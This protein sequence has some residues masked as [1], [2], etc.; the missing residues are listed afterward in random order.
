MNTNG[1]KKRKAVAV[2]FGG[3]SVEHEISIITG[4]QLIKAIDTVKYRPIPVY[5]SPQGKWYSGDALYDKNFY[6]RMPASL[7]N[8]DEVTILPEPNIKG[9][10]IRRAR[11]TA[12]A[13]Y[14]M[15]SR[16]SE[17]VI[18]VDIFLPAFH[19]TYGE[20]GCIQG[21][22]EL[23]DVPYTGCNVL[24]SALG[25]SKYHAKKLVES[26]GI[27]VLPGV[28]V[29]RESIEADYGNH[30]DFLREQV[31][32]HPGLE[33]FPLFIKPLNLGSS[34][35][36][37]KVRN[38]EEFNSAVVLALKYDVGAIVEPCLD[39]KMELNVSVIDDGDPKAS[40]VEIPVSSSGDELTYED[41]YLRGGSK[42]GD[43]TLAGMASL[44]RVI[45]PPDL[46][47]ELR[48]RARE[49]AVKAFKVL[50]CSGVSRIDFMLD[51]RTDVLY[52]NEINT[53]PGSFSFYLWMNCKPPLFYTEVITTI[54]ER[55]EDTYARKTAL[56]REIGFK[57]LF[58]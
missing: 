43:N 23:A 58:K 32:Q 12:Q 20:D 9:L 22:L 18:H 27:P 54:L 57:A 37:A 48:T 47:E 38:V 42:K 21:L 15:L 16:A 52:F 33:E 14:S 41:K 11:T 53:I 19:G 2:L 3:R 39:D 4:L 45:D 40:V 25:M 6:R 51:K 44:T 35:G 28:V 29:K 55:A 56:A 8:V 1:D 26:H 46:P 10:T 5:V 34:I 50:N 17:S 24:A 30:L 36:V 31:L 13:P 7:G 49:Y